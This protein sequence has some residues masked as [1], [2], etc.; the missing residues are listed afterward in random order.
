M[1]KSSAPILNDFKKVP[2]ESFFKY[3]KI[4]WKS[5]L[6]SI[7]FIFNLPTVQ[8]GE[9]EMHTKKINT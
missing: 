1:G 5:Y 6:A 8:W 4:L 7:E 9:G 2:I 3:R